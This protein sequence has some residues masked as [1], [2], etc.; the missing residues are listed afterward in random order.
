MTTR[1]GKLIPFPLK[2][3]HVRGRWTST[4]E[5]LRLIPGRRPRPDENGPHAA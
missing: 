1:M 4:G 5:L 3:R 2:P